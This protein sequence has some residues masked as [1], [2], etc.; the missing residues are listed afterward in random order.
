MKAMFGD[1]TNDEQDHWNPMNSNPIIPLDDDIVHDERESEQP[2][3]D[4]IG[5]NNAFDNGDEVEEVT[6]AIENAKRR[7]HVILDK[8]TKKHKTSATLRFKNTSQRYLRVLPL[9]YI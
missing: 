8:P 6:L 5:D 3:E 7:A 4:L 9:L 1:I 2:T